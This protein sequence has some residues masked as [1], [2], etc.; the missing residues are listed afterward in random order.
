MTNRRGRDRRTKWWLHSPQQWFN[1][2]LAVVTVAQ[3]LIEEIKHNDA[4]FP[5]EVVKGLLVVA[6]V[7]N[8]VLRAMPVDNERLR[9]KK[10]P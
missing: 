7:G 3:Y 2:V 6:L 8:A 10:K 5:A 1:I 4:L 9:L